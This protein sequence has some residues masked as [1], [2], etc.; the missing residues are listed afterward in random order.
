MPRS[1]QSLPLYLSGPPALLLR[2]A[3]QVAESTLGRESPPESARAAARQLMQKP[4]I[5]EDVLARLIYG[6]A[7]SPEF[8]LPLSTKGT[9]KRRA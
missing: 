1:K 3:R 5:A 7:V 4:R 9:R 2:L 8:T 6:L